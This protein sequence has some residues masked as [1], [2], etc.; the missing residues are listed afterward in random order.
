MSNQSANETTILRPHFD[1]KEKKQLMLVDIENRFVRKDPKFI[2][3][4]R[5]LGSFLARKKSHLT[6][7]CAKDFENTTYHALYQRLSTLRQLKDK[8]AAQ[9]HLN[10]IHSWYEN[11][12]D[13]L[14]DI[15]KRELV[16]QINEAKLLRRQ[17]QTKEITTQNGFLGE[18]E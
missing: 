1:E 2:E 3:M 10:K 17:Q 7:Y 12:R 9:R 4:K 15:Q 16:E 5:A 14:D 11:I 13:R 18:V 6:L 8:E